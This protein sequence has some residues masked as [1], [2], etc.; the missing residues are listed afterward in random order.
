VAVTLRVLADTDLDALFEWEREPEAVQMAAFTRPDPSDRPSFDAH[1]QRVRR[2]PSVLLRAVDDGR[3]LVGTVAS[4]MMDGDRE[5]SYWID[6]ARWGEGLASAALG[7]F[8][9]I[10]ATRP[11][12]A[13]VAEHNTG[14]A[15]V[16]TRAGFK[17]IGFGTSFADGIGRHVVEF[18]YKLDQ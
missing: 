8:L 1:Y 15:K 5:V 17:Q 16:L 2:D 13:R 7:E 11:L 12:F 10:E 9:R 6:P 14:S 18:I 3:G 4:F